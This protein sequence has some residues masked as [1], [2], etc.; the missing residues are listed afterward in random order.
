MPDDRLMEQYLYQLRNQIAHMGEADKDRLQD[1]IVHW[2]IDIQ[3]N[4]EIDRQRALDLYVQLSQRLS[5]EV[6]EK[7]HGVSHVRPIAMF[8]KPVAYV[9]WAS[10]ARPGPLSDPPTSAC[11][12]L[13]R[14]LPRSDRNV[15]R[16]DMEE[17]FKARL[18]NHGPTRARRWFW[19]ETAWTIVQHNPI[20]RS[21]LTNG[22]MR[23]GEWIFR[24]IGG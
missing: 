6:P 5:A 10:H 15:I 24:Q 9:S 21:V 4:L 22:L 1:L 16:G 13:N 3:Q 17:E 14:L 20:V 7:H 11:S 2:S 19:R 12:L 23:L 8:K 18:V